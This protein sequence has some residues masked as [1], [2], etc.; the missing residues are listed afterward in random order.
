MALHIVG[1]P[2]RAA[3][4]PPDPSP[5]LDDLERDLNDLQGQ[6]DRLPVSALGRWQYVNVTFG[7][8]D[9]DTDIAHTLRPPNPE[10]VRW[11]PVTLSAGAIIYRGGDAS[12]LAWTS[13]HIWLRASSAC[14]AR[15]LLYLEPAT[16][17]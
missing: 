6:V 13:T 16:D 17:A 14:D 11:V 3:E 10:A 2:N 8:A 5:R 7:G 1:R 12:R 9:E 15:L 4:P